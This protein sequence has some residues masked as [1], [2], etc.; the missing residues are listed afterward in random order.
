MP[1]LT[2]K[3]PRIFII[4]RVQLMPGSNIVSEADYETLKADKTGT[5]QYCITHGIILERT[6]LRPQLVPVD[7]A[8]GEDSS[9]EASPVQTFTARD[10]IEIISESASVEELRLIVATDTRKSVVAA[11]HVRIE[12]LTEEDA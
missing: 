9:L 7:K 1:V 12:A 11:A 5:F 2:L 10:A 8:T 3:K 6:D 4:N